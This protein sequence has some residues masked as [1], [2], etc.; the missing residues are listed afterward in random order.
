[1][2]S[3]PWVEVGTI[4][5]L[6]QPRT[7]TP[8]VDGLPSRRMGRQSLRPNRGVAPSQPRYFQ[9]FGRRVGPFAV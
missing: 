3:L 1:M 8:S 2:A 6:P 4:S 9:F 7:A 5:R